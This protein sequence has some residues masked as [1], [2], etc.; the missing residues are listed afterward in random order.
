M[1]ALHLFKER[2][3]VVEEIRCR[4]G[5]ARVA[6]KSGDAERAA[7]RLRAVR[8]EF[9]AIGVTTDAALAT[10]DLMESYLVLRKWRDVQTAAGNV[11]ELFREAGMLTGALTAANWLRHAARMKSVTP[12]ILDYLRSYLKRVDVQPDFAFIPPPRL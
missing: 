3:I 7:S 5:I 6:Q 1:T 9:T 2:G 8:D 12:S 4:W 11:V 10:L